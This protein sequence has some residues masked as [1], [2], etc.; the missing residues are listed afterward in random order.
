MLKTRCEANMM[1]KKYVSFSIK[2][3][4]NSKKSFVFAFYFKDLALF[5]EDFGFSQTWF[6]SWPRVKIFAKG[7][8]V[9]D[10]IIERDTLKLPYSAFEPYFKFSS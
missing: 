5:S 10:Q 3:K 2:F 8:S 1:V 7:S 4:S 9:L 6:G